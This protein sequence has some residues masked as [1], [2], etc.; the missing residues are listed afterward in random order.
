MTTY[1]IRYEKCA[2]RALDRS[3]R[4]ARALTQEFGV[5]LRDAGDLLGLSYQ[6][7]QQLT[8]NNARKQK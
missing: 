3:A 5:G 8:A 4:A 1:K 7:V 6:R 2:Q